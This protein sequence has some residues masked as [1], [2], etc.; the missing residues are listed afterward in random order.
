M[1]KLACESGSILE[2]N[3]GR[4][5]ESFKTSPFYEMLSLISLM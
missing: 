2:L 3:Q 5:F 1:W 4:D